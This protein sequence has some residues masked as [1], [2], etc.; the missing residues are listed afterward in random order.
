MGGQCHICCYT[1]TTAKVAV[2]LQTW[3]KS[4]SD[5]FAARLIALLSGAFREMPPATALAL[6]QPKLTYSN[7]ESQRELAPDAVRRVSGQP[8]DAHDRQRLQACPSRT[9]PLRSR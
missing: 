1:L 7:A 4:L 8:L 9:T 6:L 5:D 2:W 3:L